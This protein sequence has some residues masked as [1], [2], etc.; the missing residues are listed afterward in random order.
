MNEI[1]NWL[2]K[3]DPILTPLFQHQKSE[4]NV[5]Q[6]SSAIDP[7][8]Q[9]YFKQFIPFLLA[10]LKSTVNV[11]NPI[12]HSVNL[13]YVKK[14]KYRILTPVQSPS[15]IK[16]N[17]TITLFHGD[18]IGISTSLS[19]DFIAIVEND[20]LLSSDE[21]PLN[22][23]FTY[24]SSC[25]PIQRMIQSCQANHILS[26][27]FFKIIVNL[28]I[29]PI[30]STSAILDPIILRE[31]NI[32]QQQFIHSVISTDL[33]IQLLIG[34]PGSG[35][36]S[37]IVHLVNMLKSKTIVTAPTNVAV[38][39]I[40]R[41][42]I[43]S[44]TRSFIWNGNKDRLQELGLL[45]IDLYLFHSDTLVD[46]IIA[47]FYD[48]KRINDMILSDPIEEYPIKREL[49]HYLI[50]LQKLL[51]R[52]PPCKV[53][54]SLQQ[55]NDMV[56][57]LLHKSITKNDVLPVNDFILKSLRNLCKSIPFDVVFCTVSRCATISKISDI[58][59]VDEACML[60]E[61]ETSILLRNSLKKLILIGDPMQLSSVVS[62]MEAKKLHFDQSL[63]TRLYHHQ[64]PCH[65]LKLQYRMAPLINDIVSQLSYDG[66]LEMGWDMPRVPWDEDDRFHQIQWINVISEQKQH[67][68][69]YSNEME[70]NVLFK[71][72]NE[73]VSSYKS[74]ILDSGLT[75]GIIAPYKAQISL[76]LNL[77]PKSVD[78]D[79]LP[80]IECKSIDGF[81]GRERDVMIIS[82]VRTRGQGFTT[83]LRRLNVALSRA[84]YMVVI[85]GDAKNFIGTTWFTVFEYCQQLNVVLN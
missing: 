70:V 43:K 78:N 85:I 40:L 77:L 38:V 35:K 28:E 47:V 76:I 57:K 23:N 81:Q 22:C 59:V 5:E 75:F 9:Q 54:Q 71:Y 49:T 33:P 65:M 44:G 15:G 64:Y 41:K 8:L 1:L 34:P 46:A 16:I 62:N 69:S 51:N 20:V 84:R 2:K 4:L 14:H 39:N 60:I 73:F 53:R 31:L 82:L 55:R 36:T 42:Y 12:F 26:R 58:V 48:F 30:V 21:L 80:L 27:N 68:P 50:N 11:D 19:I 32:F 7:I 74:V 67:E 3:P 45:T 66:T 72:L 10:E 83:D 63:F 52:L 17:D 24:L 18:V 6:A 37:T 25:V 79:V 13:Q 56:S 29:P 61:A